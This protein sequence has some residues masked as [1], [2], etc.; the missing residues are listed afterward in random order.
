MKSSGATLDSQ[1][2]VQPP[3]SAAKKD[4]G[5][6]NSSLS[7][8]NVWYVFVLYLFYIFLILIWYLSNICVI[9]V[10][11]L[12]DIY[13]IFVKYLS[14]KVSQC[15]NSTHSGFAVFLAKS[16]CGKTF[17]SQN[18]NKKK[19]GAWCLRCLQFTVCVLSLS[20]ILGY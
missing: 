14:E 7:V 9:I 1:C 15:L 6:P 10:W 2:M 3:E 20:E 19:E 18:Q 12:C 5:C 4:S 17:V 16:I 11:Y 8:F 13:Q